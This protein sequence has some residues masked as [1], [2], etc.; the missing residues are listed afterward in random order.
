MGA[1]TG[2]TTSIFP[3]DEITK[4]FFEFQQRPFDWVKLEADSNCEYD[5]IIEIDLA[6]LEPL[7][8]LPHSPG[9]VKRVTEV[10]GLEVDQV[11]IGSCTNSSLKD[12]M[13]VAKILKGKAISPNISLIIS[14]G[15]KQVFEEIAKNGALADLIFSGARILEAACG[16]CI[17]MGQAP[18]TGG[19]SVRTFNRNF[20]GRSGTKDAQVFLVSPETAA[21]TALSGKLSDPRKF[22]AFPNIEL[23]KKIV[24]NDN[25]I[26]KPEEDTSKIEVV[27]GPNIK[28]LPI[29]S[30]LPE[31]LEFEIILKLEDDIT[32]DDIMPAGAK[33]LPLR[34]NIPAISE[35]VFEFL[36]PT[37]VG[38]IK[39]KKIGL[40]LGG[41]NYGQGSSRE[42]AALA[43]MYLG[44]K[45]VIAK[46]F[47][48]IH[49]S[50]LINFGILP[51][52]LSNPADYDKI[53]QGDIIK[54]DN[55]RAKL[56][57]GINEFEVFNKAK[58][59]KFL[60]KHD[61]SPRLRDI[62]LAGG[63]LNYV[64]NKSN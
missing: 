32:T 55:I 39:D 1:E 33:V 36:D 42:H 9:N 2:S 28:P 7:V 4:K 35:H 26:I 16:P 50:N 18:K 46:S 6:S 13:I 34:S 11:A 38:R 43:P 49:K 47:A 41:E 21:V 52:E 8:A 22:G 14:P 15:S 51:L 17:G 56:S 20:K 53:S 44:V 29:N 27:R 30:P 63:L 25:L 48:R 62:V 5:E 64:K 61:L 19:V 31:N 60:V 10:E 3:S 45:T 37:F 40:I 58:N 59:I 57:E 54:I 23:P 24:I 12:L